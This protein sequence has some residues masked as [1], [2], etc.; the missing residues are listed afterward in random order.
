ME[1]EDYFLK[2]P[3]KFWKFFCESAGRYLNNKHFTGNLFRRKI[4][5]AIALLMALSVVSQVI[6]SDII[7]PVVNTKTFTLVLD[8]TGTGILLPENVDNGS[9]DESGPVT[10]SV[11]PNV[12]S[13]IHQGPQTVT[14]TAT[15]LAGNSA[16]ADVV[17]TVASSLNINSISLNNCELAIPYALYIPEVVGGSGNYSYAWKGMEP[18]SLPFLEVLPIFP[19][20]LFTNTSVYET[21]FFNNLLPNGLYHIRLIVTDD[22]G[23]VDTSVMVLNQSGVVFDNTTIRYSEVCEG[24]TKT[25]TVN[26]DPL[27]TYNWSIENGTILTAD[28]NTSSIDVLWN[29]GMPQGVLVTTIVKPNLIGDLCTSFIIDTV[30][31]NPTPTPLFDSPVTVACIGSDVTY[32]LSDTYSDYAWVVTGGQLIA[33]GSTGSDFATVRWGTGPDGRVKCNCKKQFF[34]CINSLYRC[35]RL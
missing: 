12:F 22:N 24:E 1:R 13:C 30:T 3:A 10:L 35:L 8:A 19:Y 5:V 16:S 31:I 27:A 21:P 9:H 23:C 26:H 14:L 15:D 2:Q 17:I 28:L 6:A 29:M 11:T 4:A 33:G 34:L 18:G 7:P 25:Y 20:L 32:K